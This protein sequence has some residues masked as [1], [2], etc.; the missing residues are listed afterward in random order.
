MAARIFTCFSRGRSRL[1][2][3]SSPDA[4]ATAD[5]TAEKQRRLGPIL[6]ELFSSQDI[7]EV[8][9]LPEEGFDI[10]VTQRQ[11]QEEHGFH[12]AAK[13]NDDGS[14]AR[15][16]QRRPIRSGRRRGRWRYCKLS[17]SQRSCKKRCRL[18]IGRSRIK[19]KQ[20]QKVHE[21]ILKRLKPSSISSEPRLD[22]WIKRAQICDNLHESQLLGHFHVY[23]E[24]EKNLKDSQP[25]RL[26]VYKYR[27]AI[28]Y[29][30]EN[31]ATSIIVGET[32]SG[33]T[34]HIPQNDDVL[35]L[36][37]LAVMDHD[38]FTYVVDNPTASTYYW[39]MKMPETACYTAIAAKN[40]NR[41]PLTCQRL[42]SSQR[43]S[44]QETIKREDAERFL[45]AKFFENREI[46]SLKE[47]KRVRILHGSSLQT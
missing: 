21:A 37:L 16:P 8:F 39:R 14:D 30:V 22:E 1:R 28:L 25:D 36:L 27:K 33:K 44:K 13:E 47:R 26:P 12:F 3:S 10:S 20:E 2:H 9:R 24:S 45:A 43:I 17:A 18:R 15:V 11:L 34:T 40:T 42:G 46:K 5:L 31:H 19:V 41:R 23:S 32:G 38:F 29:L 35:G 4:N 6:L 7:E